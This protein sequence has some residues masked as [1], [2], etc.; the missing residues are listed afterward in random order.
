M[1][2]CE[3]CTPSHLL[4]NQDTSI[5]HFRVEVSSDAIASLE[6]YLSSSAYPDSRARV[7]FHVNTTASSAWLDLDYSSSLF[8]LNHDLFVFFALR[9]NP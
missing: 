9:V 3:S 6:C 7:P 4:S 2:N 5:D 1:S 8:S